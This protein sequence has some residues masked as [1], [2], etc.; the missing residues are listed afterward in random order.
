MTIRT[1]HNFHKL[2]RLCLPCHLPAGEP[3]G[4]AV[5]KPNKQE[6]S[7]RE[8][9][10][11]QEETGSLGWG[12]SRAQACSPLPQTSRMHRMPTLRARHPL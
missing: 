1:F 6:N 11:G 10:E 7:V 8:Q 4:W 2:S 12:D 3:L 9:T 5:Q